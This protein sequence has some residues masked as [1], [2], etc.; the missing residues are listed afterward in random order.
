MCELVFSEHVNENYGLGA[1]STQKRLREVLIDLCSSRNIF[2]S[3]RIADL[4]PMSNGSVKR[5]FLE[6]FSLAKSRTGE[7]CDYPWIVFHRLQTG[8]RSCG[9]LPVPTENEWR[10]IWSPQSGD[11]LKQTREQ[12]LPCTSRHALGEETAGLSDGRVWGWSLKR[13]EFHKTKMT[14]FLSNSFMLI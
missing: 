14:G 2:E 5:Y 10:V 8:R 3:S 13:G 6:N 9:Q 4:C 1:V 7:Q 12:H 11:G